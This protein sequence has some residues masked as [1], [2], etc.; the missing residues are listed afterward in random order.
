M[1]GPIAALRE[2][3]RRDEHVTVLRIGSALLHEMERRA[4]PRHAAS[5]LSLYPGM[6]IT[7]SGGRGAVTELT[8]PEAGTEAAARLV[9]A[10]HAFCCEASA[11]TQR[12]DGVQRHAQ[13][14]L[15]CMPSAGQ[16]WAQWREMCFGAAAL[17]AVGQQGDQG[18]G[19]LTASYRALLRQIRRHCNRHASLAIPS[20]RG[21]EGAAH[22]AIA[23]LRL[24]VGAVT[25]V[26]LDHAA[27]DRT[28]VLAT[29]H[30]TLCCILA[31]LRGVTKT[32]ASRTGRGM[33]GSDGCNAE[34]VLHLM[35]EVSGAL[36][37]LLDGAGATLPAAAGS[38]CNAGEGDD[39]SG[40]QP[41]CEA[42]SGAKR[43]RKLSA[44][45]AKEPPRPACV[46]LP[47]T[48]LVDASAALQATLLQ[49]ETLVT[50]LCLID[51]GWRRTPLT[52]LYGDGGPGCDRGPY[53]ASLPPRAPSPL[54]AGDMISHPYLASLPPRAPGPL[55]AGDMISHPSGLS[56]RERRALACAQKMRAV[57]QAGLALTKLGSAVCQAGLGLSRVGSMVNRYRAR[58]VSSANSGASSTAPPLLL[59]AELGRDLVDDETWARLA[60]SE[61]HLS[62]LEPPPGSCHSPGPA[63]GVAGGATAAATP[64]GGVHSIHAATALRCARTRSLLLLVLG[65]PAEA[66]AVSVNADRCVSAEA[67]HSSHAALG[68][69]ELH[70]QPPRAEARVQAS[71]LSDP[72]QATTHGVLHA[73]CGERGASLDALR[74]ALALSSRGAEAAPIALFNLLAHYDGAWAWTPSKRALKR[75]LDSPLIRPRCALSTSPQLTLDEPSVALN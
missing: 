22:G 73:C 39:G 35:G 9:S 53:S 62:S 42:G 55:P 20:N 61:A 21:S 65:Q 49:C 24:T 11:M 7:S 33:V 17:N 10:T 74:Q 72:V 3:A 25:A 27:R 66:A 58:A 44:D 41:N 8:L 29:L 60:E 14:G 63:D 16:A 30:A 5:A 52:S 68:A 32:I 69:R 38:M 1:S 40:A 37:R 36:R 51:N 59:D 46:P 70:S 43:R 64:L 34:D 48:S 71:Q 56:A 67:V 6:P 31:E 13:L 23:L 57:C 54:P 47:R 28:E 15:S 2:H 19:A 12:W 50:L 26:P 18:G 45:F 4:A 75:A